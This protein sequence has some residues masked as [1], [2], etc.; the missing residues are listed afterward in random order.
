MKIEYMLIYDIFCNITIALYTILII[1][2][3]GVNISL[4][5]SEDGKKNTKNNIRSIEKYMSCLYFK[6]YGKLLTVC[7]VSCVTLS[8]YSIFIIFI[9]ESSSL[10]QF[11]GG[12]MI[13]SLAL[14]AHFYLKQI[15]SK[16]D[17]ILKR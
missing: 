4:Q 2:I 15:N 17:E 7:T 8:V 3:S 13:L 1:M 12:V 10:K 16:F 5:K 6:C 9:N 11:T 14:I